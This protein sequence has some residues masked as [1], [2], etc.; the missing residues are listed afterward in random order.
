MK[1][2]YSEFLHSKH[3]PTIKN[4]RAQRSHFGM[5]SACCSAP[6]PVGRFRARLPY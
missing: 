2:S 3:M 5:K 1:K 6:K 4:V